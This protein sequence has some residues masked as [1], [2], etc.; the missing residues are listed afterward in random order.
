MTCTDRSRWLLEALAAARPWRGR[1]APN[2]PVGAVVERDGRCLA[3][4]AHS[5]PGTAHAEPDALSRA[6]NCE[7]ATLYVTLEPC[8]HHGRTPPCTE[9]ILAAGIRRVVYAH[10][11]ANPHVAGGGAERLRRAGL[12]VIAHP[13]P[14]ITAFYRSFDRAVTEGLPTVTAKIAVDS[15]GR[16]AGDGDERYVITGEAAARATHRSRRAHDALLTTARTANRDDPRF[17]VRLPDGSTESRPLFVW[18]RTASLRLDLRLWDSARDVV[19][20]HDP[21]APRERLDALRA[22]GA[23]L[24]PL[25]PDP[26]ASALRHIVRAGHHHLWV[27]AGGRFVQALAETPYL[28]RLVLYLGARAPAVAS[29]PVFGLPG[30]LPG[31]LESRWS[32]RA[33][34]PLG[35]DTAHVF[36]MAGDESPACDWE[37]PS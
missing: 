14:E 8:N 19:L 28:H 15:N 23:R 13:V 16:Y 37:A 25:E 32:E 18:D 24:L 12:E 27:E 11:D 30:Q 2:P 6:G 21:T 3:I 4:G 17:D 22:R 35:D 33:M 29:G 9:R 31:V 34:L 7:G 10:G 36:W 26:W 20:F 1:V 5:G